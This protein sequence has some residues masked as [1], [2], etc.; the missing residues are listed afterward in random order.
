MLQFLQNGYCVLH[1]N[2]VLQNE[3]L[4][5]LLLTEFKKKGISVD[6]P[7]KVHYVVCG[8]VWLFITCIPVYRTI[9]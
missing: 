4:L 8:S 5:S 1:Y 6:I 3:D 7:T 9:I 2:A